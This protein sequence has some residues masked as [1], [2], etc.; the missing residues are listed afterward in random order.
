MVVFEP[1][2][3]RAED[4]IYGTHLQAGRVHTWRWGQV[5]LQWP[6]K[7]SQESYDEFVDW[8]ELQMRKIARPSGIQPETQ[9]KPQLG[10]M[11][12]R[13][14]SEN[15]K[16]ASKEPGPEAERLKIGGD[17][18]KNVQAALTKKR[19]KVGWPKT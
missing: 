16:E 14:W 2:L 9:N 10:T 17:W 5:I 12:H 4:R 3:C 1:A 18:R 19:P 6:E 11:T 7:M 13:R 8:I 15:E